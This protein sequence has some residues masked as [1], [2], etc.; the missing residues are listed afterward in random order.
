[1]SLFQRSLF[2]NRNKLRVWDFEMLS[3]GSS[4]SVLYLLIIHSATTNCVTCSICKE[5]INTSSRP[6]ATMING[7][8]V[9]ILTAQ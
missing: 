6:T 3:Q 9:S 5:L 7:E 1:M 2:K 4:V 8:K